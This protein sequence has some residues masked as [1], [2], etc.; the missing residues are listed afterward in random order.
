MSGSSAWKYPSEDKTIDFDCS[1][2]LRRN[3]HE[4]T[5]I[6]SFESSPVGLMFSN[7]AFSGKVAQA[8]ISGG[9]VTDGKDNQLYQIK[10][11]FVTNVDPV[12]TEY[13]NFLVLP[14]EF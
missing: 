13:F 9:E 12:V 7:Q 6:T 1:P 10:V 14:G 8:S 4:I 2:S 11:T 5:G 3:A